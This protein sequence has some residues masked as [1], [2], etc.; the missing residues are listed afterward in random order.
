MTLARLQQ[1]KDG[2]GKVRVFHI[3][4]LFL[5]RILWCM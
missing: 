3:S 5:Y 2:G 1:V 4:H